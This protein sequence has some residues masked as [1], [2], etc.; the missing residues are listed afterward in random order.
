MSLKAIEPRD[1]NHPL[2]STGFDCCK[3]IPTSEDNLALQRHSV[4]RNHEP[5]VMNGEGFQNV[6]LQGSFTVDVEQ[7]ESHT[8]PF[9][10]ERK[11]RHIELSEGP[12]S[13]SF[14]N[15]DGVL[16]FPAQHE[17]SYLEQT[18]VGFE[19]RWP[20]S[21]RSDSINR[22]FNLEEPVN[23]SKTSYLDVNFHRLDFL[24]VN[25][26]E[27]CGFESSQPLPL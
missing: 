24:E 17:F 23:V 25:T 22:M 18:P 4:P 12:I 19:R 21:D 6:N 5:H 20:E 7:P 26:G 16:S 13:D 8:N 2:A 27:C 14:L 9:L 3:G 1:L 15:F 11:C 10:S